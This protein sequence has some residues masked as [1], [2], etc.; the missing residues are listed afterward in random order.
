[1]VALDIEIWPSSTRFEAGERLRL[2]VQ[3]SDIRKY[4][5]TRAH[6]YFRHE[7]SVNCGLHVIHTGPQ[8]DSYL[9]VPIIP[10]HSS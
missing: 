8:H 3:G 2:V 10:P 7:A 5:K 6:V 9:L 1:V 4:P